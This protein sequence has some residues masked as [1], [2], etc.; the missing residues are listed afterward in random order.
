MNH[1]LLLA[2]KLTIS[3]AAAII[4]FVPDSLFRQRAG[5]PDY[6]RVNLRIVTCLE[7]G[8]V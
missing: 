8:H 5:N 1:L 3:I 7:R 2:R 6:W 4:S